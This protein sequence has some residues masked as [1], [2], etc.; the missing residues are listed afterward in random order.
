MKCLYCHNPDTIPQKWGQEISKEEIIETVNK[1]K[2]YFWSKW[3]VTFSGGECLIQAEELIPVFQELKNQGI[4]I[5]IDTNGYIFN[6]YVEELLTYTDLVLLD[7]KH[8]YDTEHRK[9]TWVSNKTI[10]SFAKYLEDANIKFWVRHVLVPGMTDS[11]QHLEDL[12][13]YLRDFTNLE[14]FEIL[15]Y[16]TLWVYK[17]KE[18]WL[19]YWLEWVKP[20]SSEQLLEA[21]SLLEKHLK[22]VFIRR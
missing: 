19:P 17:W 16:H 6:E 1:S 20:P 5:T 15:P 18:M 21:K 3:W 22:S 9:L 8:F 12:W 11:E 2:A 10:L 14:R 4:H 7:I 13:R